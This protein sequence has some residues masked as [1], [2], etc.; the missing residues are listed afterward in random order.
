M[1]RD[2]NAGSLHKQLIE[3][4]VKQ[5]EKHGPGFLPA[6]KLNDILTED[7]LREELT[8]G[9]LKKRIKTRIKTR[10]WKPA[11]S[12]E[13]A[14]ERV[15][16][17]FGKSPGV[18][19]EKSK[20]RTY[21]KIMAILLLIERQHKIRSFLKHQLHDEDLPLIPVAKGSWELRC[22]KHPDTPL[23]CFKKW[24]GDSIRKFAEWQWTVL[25]P[26]FSQGERKRFEPLQT[27]P[28]TKWE[29]VEKG[30]TSSVYKARIHPDHHNFHDMDSDNSTSSPVT[31][32]F[33][34]SHNPRQ[35]Q[36]SQHS[37]PNVFAIKRLDNH[38]AKLNFRKE[39]GALKKVSRSSHRHIISLLASYEHHENCYLIFPWAETDLSKFWQTNTEYGT[40]DMERWIAVQCQGLADG[41]ATIHREKTTS[42][43]SLMRQNTAVREYYDETGELPGGLR[44][45]GRHGDIKPE[46]ILWFPPT[47][48]SYNHKGTLKIADFGSAELST[49]PGVP[50]E[51]GTGSSMYQPPEASPEFAEATLPKSSY[52]I[53]SLGC[54]YLEFT[55]WWFGGPQLVGEFLEKRLT[56][57]NLPVKSLVDVPSFF[58]I[59]QDGETS[60][61]SRQGPSA[62]RVGLKKSVLQVC[63]H[64]FATGS[65]VPENQTM[66]LKPVSKVC[67]D[68]TTS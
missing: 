3:A 54:L 15:Q 48:G 63:N 64:F 59:Q 65:L 29:R 25:A 6:K 50:K 24:S 42:M 56:P 28:F 7:A 31:V 21:L 61:S 4:L 18:G 47:R 46:N 38:A 16:K 66:A 68:N 34:I 57:E 23:S 60:A 22:K 35:D 27:L 5:P 40:Q 43:D 1:S 12:P 2:S 8:T 26:H 41:L 39:V 17:V 10:N 58:T 33:A 51:C 53:W 30:G 32:T 44:L 67:N 19:P 49:K 37:D 20:P 14:N 45:F 55:A 52:D 11:P 13:E 9:S 62:Q 36:P